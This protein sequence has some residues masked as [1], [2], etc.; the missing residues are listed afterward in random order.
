MSNI[1]GQSQMAT[2]RQ[3]GA[4]YLAARHVQVHAGHARATSRVAQS[5]R[6]AESA[7][8][9]GDQ[10]SPLLRHAKT[11]VLPMLGFGA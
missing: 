4:G 8:R 6:L 1:G 5:E 3:Q 10:D 9:A 11:P 7:A 2:A